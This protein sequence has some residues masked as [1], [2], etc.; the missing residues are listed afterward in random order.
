MVEMLGFSVIEASN[1]KEALELYRERTAEIALVFTDM[2][3]PVM[4]GYE[5]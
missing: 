3:V 4:D 1:G 2:G 5:L